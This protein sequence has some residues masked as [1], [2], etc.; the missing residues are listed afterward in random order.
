MKAADALRA[1]HIAE[2]NMTRCLRSDKWADGGTAFNRLAYTVAR[3]I[4][5]ACKTKYPGDAKALLPGREYI[6]EGSRWDDPGP[7]LDI[8]ELT[9]DLRTT[10]VDEGLNDGGAEDNGDDDD[11]DSDQASESDLTDLD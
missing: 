8:W 9:D 6:F 7:P 3:K 1:E 4:L 5:I 11:S 2:Y 10:H